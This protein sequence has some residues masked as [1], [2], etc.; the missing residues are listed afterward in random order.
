MIYPYFMEK[1][2]G[3]QPQPWEGAEFD[4]ITRESIDYFAER[5][6]YGRDLIRPPGDEQ[7]GRDLAELLHAPPEINLEHAN[8]FSRALGLN[9][10]PAIFVDSKITHI[11]FYELMRS[12]N[13]AW[14]RGGAQ[15]IQEIETTIVYP[16]ELALGGVGRD[17]YDRVV[18]H[19]NTHASGFLPANVWNEGIARL[20]DM[21]YSTLQGKVLKLSHPPYSIQDNGAFIIGGLCAQDPELFKA[22]LDPLRD[23]SVANYK[24]FL[25]RLFTLIGPRKYAY[26]MSM[27]PH[28]DQDFMLE[29]LRGIIPDEDLDGRRIPLDVILPYIKEEVA[30]Y[31]ERTGY[32]FNFPALASGI[33]AVALEQHAEL[34]AGNPNAIAEYISRLAGSFRGVTQS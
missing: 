33:G 28:Q 26:L 14:H 12:S 2:G 24:V 31:E 9:P 5:I 27:E 19:E 16:P 22:M 21:A 6:V 20:L 32:R 25:D 23:G 10:K 29:A 34:Q 7:R 1:H 11:E 18:V 3:G 15:F 17:D 4:W 30:A 8:H 13:I